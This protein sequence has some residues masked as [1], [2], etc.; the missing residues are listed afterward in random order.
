MPGL[1][2]CCWFWSFVWSLGNCTGDNCGRLG[3]L[4]AGRVSPGFFRLGGLRG[5]GSHVKSSVKPVNDLDV[6]ALFAVY[7]GAHGAWS[8][9][10]LAASPG[11]RINK[12][13]AELAK[14]C[15]KLESA[16]ASRK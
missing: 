2:V 16:R 4:S 14:F 15:T 1:E 5:A 12:Q 13:I 8:V 6:R 9:P 3:S 11:Q 7:G 10:M